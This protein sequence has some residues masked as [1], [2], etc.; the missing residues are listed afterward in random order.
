MYMVSVSINLNSKYLAINV[1]GRACRG[2]AC[3]VHVC[4]L[5]IAIE[6]FT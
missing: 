4:C 3:G 6:L 1:C 2:P 5:Q